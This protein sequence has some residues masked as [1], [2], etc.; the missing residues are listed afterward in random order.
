MTTAD[1]DQ[2]DA[3]TPNEKVI[4]IVDFNSLATESTYKLLVRSSYGTP[5]TY[6]FNRSVTGAGGDE[7]EA[8]LSTAVATEIAQ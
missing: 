7:Y 3:S 4:K 5:L 1:Y 2:N 6:Y 8:G